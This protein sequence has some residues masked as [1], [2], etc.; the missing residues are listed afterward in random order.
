MYMYYNKMRNLEINDQRDYLSAF[1]NG[2][3][4]L[5]DILYEDVA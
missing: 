4:T 2:G 1:I 5:A 3:D